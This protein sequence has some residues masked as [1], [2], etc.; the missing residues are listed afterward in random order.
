MAAVTVFSSSNYYKEGRGSCG[1]LAVTDGNELQ[2]D[3]LEPL[4]R[5]AKREDVPLFTINRAPDDDTSHLLSLPGIV[6]PGLLRVSVNM[7]SSVDRNLLAQKTFQARNCEEPTHGSAPSRCPVSSQGFLIHC[8]R[9]RS[10]ESSR[11]ER[12]VGCI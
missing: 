4:H 7:L 5:T 6:A 11:H 9:P 1:I 10:Q 3:T 8:R 2:P 12:P